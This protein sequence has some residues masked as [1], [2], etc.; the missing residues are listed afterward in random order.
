V[1]PGVRVY[2]FKMSEILGFPREVLDRARR[3]R[4]PRFDGK[5]FIAVLSTGIYCRSICPVRLY[6]SPVRYYASAAESA[7]AGFRP[8]LR[9]RPEAAPGSPAWTGKSAVVRRA[10]RLIHEGAL[11]MNSVEE[12]AARVGVGAR[13]LNRL[14]V[15]QIGASP[16]AIA[17]TRRLHFAKRLLDDTDLPVTEI[18]LAAG[19]GSVRRFNSALKATYKRSPRE[20]RKRRAVKSEASDE[21]TLRLAF[22]PP[23]DW[24]AL[25]GFLARR[26]VAGIER[27][28][29]QGYARTVRTSTGHAR[30]EVS[31][32]GDADALL[33]RVRGAPSSDLF[34]LSS[35]VRRVFD[36]A[37]D[38][39][40]IAAAFQG[41]VRLSALVAKRPGLRIPG[42][43]EPFE[44]AVRAI[45]GE[46]K[47]PQAARTQ[48]RKLVERLGQPIAST[49]QGLDYV[50]PTAQTVAACA[51]TDL[52][53][54]PVRAHAVRQLAQALC[55]GRLNFSESVEHVT[56]A[57]SK[58]PALGASGASYVAL[59]AMG[60]PDAFPTADLALRRAAN[61]S[62]TALSPRELEARGESWRPW[63]GYAAFHLWTTA[64]D[65]AQP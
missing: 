1:P 38:P 33:V 45:A 55:D 16:L 27:V 58:V 64:A 37:A 54:P 18:A 52:C 46:Q 61:H 17:Q 51:L 2:C 19:Y 41:D 31:R 49:E 30:I 42:V 48:L 14:L 57:L 5:F 56:L 11:D 24:N 21:I 60:E 39:I 6:T 23:Y 3:S 50:F 13:Y 63:R 59:R 9:C 25:L 40:Q 34:E 43:W 53:L 29:A 15:E 62:A 4:D 65:E 22:R 47:T 28:N 10:L 7:A 8:C 20:L 32:C 44:G 26:A 35:R 12:L 36:L